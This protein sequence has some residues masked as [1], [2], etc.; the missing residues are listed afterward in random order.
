VDDAAFAGRHGREAIRSAG[1]A[2]ALRRNVGRGSQL[3]QAQGTV[4]HAIEAYLLVLVARQ[5]Q[6]LNREQ[7]DR[8]QQFRAT[9]EKQAAVRARKFHQDFWLLPVAILRQRRI[10]GNPILQT[11]PGV[12]NNPTQEFVDLFGS[13]DFVGNSHKGSFQ[14]SAISEAV[15][16]KDFCSL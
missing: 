12:G 15:E 13:G 1:L 6:H 5:T 9:L 2:Y 11:E 4:V 7:F 8:P 14:L 3:F 16:C 10:D